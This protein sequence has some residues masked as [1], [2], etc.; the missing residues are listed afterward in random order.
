MRQR[1]VALLVAVGLMLVAWAT[2][3]GGAARAAVGDATGPLVATDLGG[4]AVLMTHDLVPGEVRSGEVTVTNAGDVG[5]AFALIEQDL[6][7]TPSPGGPLSAVVD[8]IVEDVV[9]GVVFSGK[10]RELGTVPLGDLT[11]GEARRYRFTVRFPEGALDDGLQGAS[12]TA[13]FVWGAEG[14]APAREPAPATAAAP[15][16]PPATVAG[17]PPGAKL[18]A[19]ST[20]SGRH[21]AVLA[22]IACEARCSATLSAIVAAGRT[23]TPLRAVRRMLAQP[24]TTTVRLVLTPGVRAAL[25]RGQRVEVRLRLRVVVAG[26]TVTAQRTVRVTPGR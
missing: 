5:G 2:G 18:H 21:G 7:D 15:P 10:L 26:R 6:E 17:G 24:G 25:A 9:R 4:G 19:R 16:P 22:T 8:L 11:Q 12:T 3:D 13:T 1:L 20:Q 23:T 14:A